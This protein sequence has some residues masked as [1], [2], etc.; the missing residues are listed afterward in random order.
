M[1][2]PEIVCSPDRCAAADEQSWDR[3]PIVIE[4]LVHGRPK[5]GP[6]KAP[7]SAG[8]RTVSPLIRMATMS[9]LFSRSCKSWVDAKAASRPMFSTQSPRNLQAA[10]TADA[11]YQ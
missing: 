8:L 4:S 10:I 2:A 11:K 3:E 6:P 5:Q 9:T 1:G 7:A